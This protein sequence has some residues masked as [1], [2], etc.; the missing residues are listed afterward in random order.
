MLRNALAARINEFE[1]FKV[2]DQCS[3]GKELIHTLETNP[4]PDLV[5]L[6]KTD[7]LSKF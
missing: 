7:L 6:R 2:V 3:H 1:N 5:L 4:E